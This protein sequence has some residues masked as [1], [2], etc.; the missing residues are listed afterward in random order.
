M[1]AICTLLQVSAT[2]AGA[3]ASL[4][5][6]IDTWNGAEGRIANPSGI[7]HIPHADADTDP[8]LISDVAYGLPEKLRGSRLTGIDSNL[9]PTEREIRLGSAVREPTGLAYHPKRKTL[10]VTDDDEV[11]L[12]EIDLRGQLKR[13]I[14]LSDVGASDPEGVACDPIGDRLFIADGRA[15]QI[16]EL[17]ITGEH[18]RTFDVEDVPG[19][20]EA[21]GI[22]Y[23]ARN[24]HL[25]VVAGKAGVLFELD[26][27]GKVFAS[28]DLTAIGATRPRG[29]TL[30]PSSDPED[31]QTA[32][33]LFVVDDLAKKGPTSQLFEI[34]LTQR[35]D[36]A[37]F[38]S[39]LVGDVDGFG[40]RGTEPGF[41]RGDLDHN[42]LLEPGEQLPDSVLGA[43]PPA[44]NRSRADA[45]GTD[46]MLLATA[47]R[48]I[49][50][51]HTF[52]PPLAPRRADSPREAP[53]RATPIWARLT[54]LVADARTL[55][56][57]RNV[58]RVEGHRVGEVVGSMQKK[59]L[60][61]GAIA[62]TVIELP[63]AVLAEIADGRAQVEIGRDPDTGHDDIMI[64]YSRLEVAFK[65]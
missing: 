37:H 54:L 60:L 26:Q 23:D 7:T 19:F 46:A 36:R 63:K 50:V 55:T 9:H 14:D 15:Q 29:V 18:I 34:A 5:R 52:G 56:G 42:G 58:I 32:L 1:V 10:F 17:T 57:S 21:Q 61:A 13:S 47:E 22:A 31:A 39:S 44:D 49:A 35:P 48:P 28:F 16:L 25:Y 41:A 30:A 62:T 11:T 64:D 8:F 38:V 43:S 3:A 33:H 2:G 27:D 12:Y 20:R 4:V 65:E 51:E 45:S 53:S 59:K 24:G 40:F 6:R